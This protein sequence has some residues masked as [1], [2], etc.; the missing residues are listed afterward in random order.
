LPAVYISWHQKLIFK[1]KITSQSLDLGLSAQIQVG[2]MRDDKF[3]FYGGKKQKKNDG[4]PAWIGSRTNSCPRV[5]IFISVCGLGPRSFSRMNGNTSPPK[6]DLPPVQPTTTSSTSPNAASCCRH[7]SPMTLPRQYLVPAPAA[8]TSTASEMVMSR[9]LGLARTLR[10]AF[11]ASRRTACCPTARCR[12]RSPR[13]SPLPSC[14][15]TP[16]ARRFLAFA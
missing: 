16:A 9:L 15:T 5:C 8:A 12:S 11:V 13:S 1:N 7:S 10:P 2:P 4:P 6:L 3:I 14:C